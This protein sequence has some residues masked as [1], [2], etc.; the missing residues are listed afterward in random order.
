[1]HT[2][3]LI[4]LHSVRTHSIITSILEL[5]ASKKI[6]ASKNAEVVAEVELLLAVDGKESEHL[7]DLEQ[8]DSH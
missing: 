4:H 8:D 6:S 5:W 1:M 2:H 3:V 7:R